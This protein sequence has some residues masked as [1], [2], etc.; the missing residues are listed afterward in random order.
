M[1]KNAYTVCVALTARN[2]SALVETFEMLG[3]K[4]LIQSF[5]VANPVLT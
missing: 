1:G 4:V 3:E 2:N 5:E